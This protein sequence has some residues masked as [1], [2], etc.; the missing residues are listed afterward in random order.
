MPETLD[1]AEV[2]KT[3]EQI[4]RR[5]YEGPVAHEHTT[6]NCPFTPDGRCRGSLVELETV[7]G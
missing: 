3:G 6:D 7:P 2:I 1:L 5:R 4:C